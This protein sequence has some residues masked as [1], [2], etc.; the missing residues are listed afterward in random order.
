MPT[1]TTGPLICPECG[2]PAEAG[3]PAQPDPAA[4]NAWRHRDD[5]SPLCPTTAV[6][7]SDGDVAVV[8]ATGWY[9]PT[10]TIQAAAALRAAATY[11]DYAL[12][13]AV[14]E[15]AAPR[16]D[17]L[18][19]LLAD[20]HHTVGRLADAV[21][22]AATRERSFAGREPGPAGRAALAR[23]LADRLTDTS[24]Q[25]A[26][27]GRTLHGIADDHRHLHQQTAIN[28]AEVGHAATTR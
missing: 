4:S 7:P 19:R 13:P 12:T 21:A 17:D 9:G 8:P 26:L 28:G 22:H 1:P 16:P 5:T 25:L 3:P 23:L 2:R 24:A 10:E 14:A 27:T 6:H 15:I 20:L 11:L 18:T